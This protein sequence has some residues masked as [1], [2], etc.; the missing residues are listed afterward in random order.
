MDVVG[1]GI[2]VFLMLVVVAVWTVWHNH[3]RPRGTGST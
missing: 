3:N 1:P 2:A